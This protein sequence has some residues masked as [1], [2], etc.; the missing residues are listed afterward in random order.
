M[1]R[2]RFPVWLT[3]TLML[4]SWSPTLH[5]T[6]G[7]TAALAWAE[8]PADPA[9]SRFLAGQLVD[10]LHAVFGEHAGARAAHAK[11]IVLEG[12]FKPSRAATA[13]SKAPHLQGPPVPVTVRFS[14]FSGLPT[15]ADSDALSAPRGLAV[16]FT[17]PNGAETDIV[18]HSLNGFPS[19]TAADFRD[20]LMATA[21]SG[22]QAAPPTALDT[23]LEKHPVAKATLSR[24]Q[25][26]PVSYATQ[27]YFAVNA[28]KF[29]NARKKI[30]YGRYRL[31]PAA[32]AHYLSAEQVTRAAP[33]F[34]GDELR[35]RMRR[36]PVKF[37]LALQLAQASDNLN[38]PSIPWPESRRLITLGVISLAR[39]VP[40]QAAADK[41]LLFLPSAVTAGIQPQDPMINARSNSYVVSFERRQ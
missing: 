33:D 40:N 36:G 19:A 41:A 31:L 6:R 22:P 35:R 1:G 12:R 7:P 3:L 39:V 26:V 38:D 17:L 16:K 27:P 25:P 14:A 24:P 4:A 30:V 13:V 37:T 8:A 10:G 28:F 32:G 23:Y 18:A 9:D 2:S 20:L 15:I 21:K 29:T 5:V 11:G 34:L